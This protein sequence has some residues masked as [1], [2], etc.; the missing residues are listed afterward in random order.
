MPLFLLPAQP[1]G[2]KALKIQERRRKYF[3][4]CLSHKQLC[5]CIHAWSNSQ[6]TRICSRQISSTLALHWQPHQ[7]SE[8]KG[9]NKPS[10]LNHCHPWRDF[11]LWREKTGSNSTGSKAG[12]FAT[13]KQPAFFSAGASLAPTYSKFSFF[14]LLICHH[15]SLPVALYL[16]PLYGSHV[17]HC[18]VQIMKAQTPPATGLWVVNLP[19]LCSGNPCAVF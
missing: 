18:L 9:W 16:I 3:W 1:E 14:F 17:Q 6:Q 19:Y 10:Q 11:F 15:N 8:P 4:P 5:Q 12:V 7:D 13:N 2:G